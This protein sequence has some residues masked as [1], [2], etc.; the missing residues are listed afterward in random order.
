[1]LVIH[2]LE[3]MKNTKKLLKECN[4]DIAVIPDGLTALVQPLDEP[5]KG[6]FTK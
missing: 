6:T 2:F 4:A 5:F 3:S 1:M